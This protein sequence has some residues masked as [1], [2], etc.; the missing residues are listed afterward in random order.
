M[1]D[2]RPR[3]RTPTNPEHRAVS[4]ARQKPLPR[5]GTR[6]FAER[7]REGATDTALNLAGMLRDL[8]ADFRSAD[9]FFKYKAGIIAA[10]VLLSVTSFFIACPRSTE[11]DI[12]ARLVLAGD[13][14]RPIYMVK[15]EGDEP[16]TEVTI[17]VN[18]TYRAAVA[19]IA[20]NGDVTL[21]PKQLL[22]PDGNIA[23]PEL[24][25][26]ELE[27]RTAEGNTTLLK[28]GQRP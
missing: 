23:P 7:L 22:G 13:S 8:V 15:N 1:S 18:G 4:A 3:P 26:T 6:L 28:A 19:Q 9:R 20:P 11:N 14:T 25:V 5:A 17:I 16:W 10:W 27:V 24:K 12:G 21:T 2:L